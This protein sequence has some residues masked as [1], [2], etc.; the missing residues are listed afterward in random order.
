MQSLATTRLSSKGQVV[1][2]EDIRRRLGLES[3]DQFVVVGESGVVVLQAIKPPSLR[4]FDQLI[5]AARRQAR[6]A[7]LKKADIAKAVARVRNSHNAK[8]AT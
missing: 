7:G 2:P 3:G 1:I 4:D 5:D 8:R 6:Q